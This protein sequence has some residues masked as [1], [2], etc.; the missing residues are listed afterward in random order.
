MFWI[1]HGPKTVTDGYSMLKDDIEYRQMVAEKAGL[2]FKFGQPELHELHENGA[3]VT[4]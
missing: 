1:G 4:C 2:G 3:L